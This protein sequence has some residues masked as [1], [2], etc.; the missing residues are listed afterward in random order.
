MS[1]VLEIACRLPAGL[2]ANDFDKFTFDQF[3]S[4][5]THRRDVLQ[6]L[7]RCAVLVSIANLAVTPI[8]L[9]RLQEMAEYIVID[10]PLVPGSI[11]PAQLG[12]SRHCSR[13]K[14]KLA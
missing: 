4:P 7:L 2:L 10:L 8:A 9:L 13:T 5:K 12:Y 3:D 1:K 14:S 6:H 11:R